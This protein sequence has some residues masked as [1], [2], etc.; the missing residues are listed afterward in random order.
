MYRS[1]KLDLLRRQIAFRVVGQLLAEDQDGIK[2]R[3]QLMRHIGEE[4]RLVLRSERK[5]GRLFLQCASGLFDFLVLALDF[6]VSFGKLLRLLLQLLVCL[7]QF[8]LLRLQL[9]GKLLRLRQ[10]AFGL[11]R[12]LD[13]IEHDADEVVS[14][15]KNMVC[16]AV[17]SW[18]EASSITALT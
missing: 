2:R 18:I 4:L 10:Q 6:D 12:C 3:A 14:C 5:L 13:R 17:N 16:K 7:L 1:R 8:L 11:H 15:S 9:R